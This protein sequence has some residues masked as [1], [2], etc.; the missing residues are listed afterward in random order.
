MPPPSTAPDDSLHR[1]NCR[2]TFSKHPPQPWEF[3]FYIPNPNHPLHTDEK[4]TA[5][6]CLLLPD[7]YKRPSST[8]TTN[9]P[10]H[11]A[12]ALITR[13]P[14]SS[15]K[16]K[17]YL[18]FRPH[19]THCTCPRTAPG[20]LETHV[21]DRALGTRIPSPTCTSY[22]RA[23]VKNK[24]HFETWSWFDSSVIPIQAPK[25]VH[26]ECLHLMRPLTQPRFGLVLH[27]A[28]V[29]RLEMALGRFREKGRVVVGPG[30]R[31]VS[32]KFL[33]ESKASERGDVEKSSILAL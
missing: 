13:K 14:R 16:S 2:Y 20:E 28:G 18:V 12:I 26:V 5:H 24:G 19:T 6:F 25:T 3:L 22:D 31:K 23:D 29:E 10:S 8:T 33:I 11:R 30:V 7:A 9:L 32:E 17:G 4:L 15:T 1:H 27:A 21:V